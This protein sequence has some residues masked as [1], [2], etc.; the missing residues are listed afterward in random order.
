[1]REP[2][3]RETVSMH[4]MTIL[5]IPSLCDLLCTLLLLVA[6]LYITASLWQMMRGSIII[7]TALMKRLALNHRLKK[8]MWLGVII[9]TVAMLLVASTSFLGGDEAASANPTGKD[10]RI[11]ILLV[12]VGCLAQGVQCKRIRSII[13]IL[14]LCFT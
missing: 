10:P 7:I 5:V 8:H 11:G 2:K 3:D 12:V 14:C 13:Y 9:I 6:Q 1:M 4:T